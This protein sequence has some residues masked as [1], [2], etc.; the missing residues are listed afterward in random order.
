MVARELEKAGMPKDRL[1]VEAMGERFASTEAMA[2]D[3]AFERSV[4]IRSN[5]AR[6]SPAIERKVDAGSWAARSLD[7]AARSQPVVPAILAAMSSQIVDF[8]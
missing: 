5:R 4:E 2:D 6:P 7:R 8:R 3:Q 1:I